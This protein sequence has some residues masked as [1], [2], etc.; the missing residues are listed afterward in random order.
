M[1]RVLDLGGGGGGGGGGVSDFYKHGL[2]D[3]ILKARY[4]LSYK[5]QYICCKI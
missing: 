4:K 3:G 2:R 5:P 1:I